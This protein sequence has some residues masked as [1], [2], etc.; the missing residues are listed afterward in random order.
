[1]AQVYPSTVQDVAPTGWRARG[2]GWLMAVRDGFVTLLPLTFFGVAALLLLD[3]PSQAYQLGMTGLLGPEWRV[4]AREVVD[5]THGLFG[6][7]L[8]PLVAVSIARR[9]APIVPGVEE[10]PVVLIGLSALANFMLYTVAR[11]PLSVAALGHDA[12]VAGIVI[13][14]LSSELLRGLAGMRWVSLLAMPYDTEPTF[15]HAMRLTMP[16]ILLGLLTLALSHAPNLLAQPVSLAWASLLAWAS[17]DGHGIWWLNLLAV[18]LNQSVWFFGAHG[19]HVLDT[20]ASALFL[21]RGAAY[22]GTLAWRPMFDGFVLLGGS[23]ATLG[24]LLAIAFVVREGPARRV[25]HLSILPGIF[26]INET[27]LYGLPVVLNRLFLLPFI[28]VPLALMAISLSAVQA[29]FV[30]MRPVTIPWTTPPLVSGWLLTGS[31]RGVAIQCLGLVLSL[32]L[33]LP[34]VRRAEA[35]RKREQASALGRTLDAILA[36]GR[37][38]MPAVQRDDQVGL[39]A[40]GLLADLRAALAVGGLDLAYQPKH[41]EDG[42]VV[43]VEALLRWPHARHGRLPP[44]VAVVLAEDS[45]DIH[46]LGKQVM[47]RAF[48]CKKRWNAQGFGD[49]SMAVNVSPLQLTDPGFVARVRD[50]LR[51]HDLKP[52]EIELEITESQAIPDSQDVDKTLGDLSA[53]GV[54]LAMD[55]FGMGYSSLLHLRRFH[56][57]AIKIDGS[58]SRDVLANAASA[59]IV[60]TIAALGRS[61]EVLVVAEYVETQ[62]QRDALARLGCECFQGYLYSPALDE[63]GCIEY[64]GRVASVPGFDPVRSA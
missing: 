60:R 19:G 35:Q 43:G 14:I 37:R 11:G 63:V 49:V 59:D 42:R 16:V 25:A 50:L 45:G 30:Q 53:M 1:M 36:D 2:H 40:R 51:H 52:D 4:H 39:I 56:V 32:A 64:F 57:H 20:Y 47:E 48:A 5:A 44:A 58:L 46:A 3:F 62:A 22:D 13:G 23:G 27:I 34:F 7:I 54:R 17:G 24:L 6:M 28:L 55:D 41:A 61:Q 12:I 10:I 31:W 26:N 18:L 9:R 8:C 21:P 15:F 29:G 38:H 33:Y